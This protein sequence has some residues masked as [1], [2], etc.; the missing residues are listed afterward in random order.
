V[1][2]ALYRI[3]Q[4]GLSNVV[5]HAG[6]SRAIVRLECT[7]AG[8]TLSIRDDG[9]GF[10]PDGIGAHHLGLGI[11][12]ERA[13]VIGAAFAIASEPESGTKIT[14]AWEGAQTTS[15]GQDS[16]EPSGGETA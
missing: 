3:A 2:L 16:V 13:Q 5:K 10:D 11:M 9:R 1:K 4:E 8:I 14:V 7:G 15:E 12:R 6:A